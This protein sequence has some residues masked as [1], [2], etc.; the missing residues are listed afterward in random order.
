[1]KSKRLVFLSIMAMLVITLSGTVSSAA[2]Q[3]RTTSSSSQAASNTFF[4]PTVENRSSAGVSTVSSTSSTSTSALAPQLSTPKLQRDTVFIDY[5]RS[6]IVMAATSRNQVYVYLVGSLPDPCHM[7][8]ISQVTSTS[9]N[10]INLDVYSLYDPTLACITVIQPFTVTYSLG[11]FSP[12]MYSMF[13]NGVK[14]GTFEI[15]T[16]TT[17]PFS[18]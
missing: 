16:S 15:S 5:S 13:V 6:M 1:M 7:L 17:T 11:S 4:I 3:T 8:R 10:V 2:A 9:S 18:R 14:L 12:G